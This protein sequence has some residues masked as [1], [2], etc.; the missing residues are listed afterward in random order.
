MFKT[1]FLFEIKR[2]L[3]QPVFYVYCAIYFALAFFTTISALG[4]FDAVTSTTSTAVYLNSPINIAGF[5]NSFATLIYFLLPTIIGA[6]VYRDY[7]YNV[8][9]LLF[10]YP[11]DKLNYLSAKFLSSFV[12]V[13]LIAVVCAIGYYLGQFYP[14]INPELLG[15][16]NPM[17]HIVG[18]LITVLPNFIL[19]RTTVV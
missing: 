4:A 19:D 3:K 6:S 12:V 15:P 7:L 5:F 8:H 14:G 1:I 16:T 11:L 13:T 10:S 17:A 2:W 18:F 9:T